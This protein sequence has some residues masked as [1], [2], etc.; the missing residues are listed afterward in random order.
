[1]R[2]TTWRADI[3]RE[4][5]GCHAKHLEKRGFRM[6]W[7]TWR[8][9]RARFYLGLPGTPQPRGDQALAPLVARPLQLVRRARGPPRPRGP[10]A[11]SPHR[12]QPTRHWVVAADNEGLAYIAR[13]VIGESGLLL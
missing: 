12:V 3:A 9:L 11:L 13:H 7:T 1:M 8:A 10:L 2:W 5:I 4:V 6:R